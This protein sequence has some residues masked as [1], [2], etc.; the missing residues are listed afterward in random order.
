MVDGFTLN[1]KMLLFYQT[2]KTTFHKFQIKEPQTSS[3]INH[4]LQTETVA[5]PLDKVNCIISV[6][7]L[8][9]LKPIIPLPSISPSPRNRMEAKLKSDIRPRPRKSR[10]PG[11]AKA[12]WILAM[13]RRKDL[14]AQ[15]A[16]PRPMSLQCRSWRTTRRSR[17]TGWSRCCGISFEPEVRTHK[18]RATANCD[19][20]APPPRDC[21]LNFIKGL[22]SCQDTVCLCD[23]S[24]FC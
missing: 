24:V 8:L 18:H 2:N 13:A 12:W 9:L 17:R 23:V 14:S 10:K 20:L 11:P 5:Y 7:S 15:L 21:W 6:D 22:S 1:A 4:K 3:I 19:A 16:R